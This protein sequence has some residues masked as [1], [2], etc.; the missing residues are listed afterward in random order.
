MLNNSIIGNISVWDGTSIL[1][2]NS[3]ISGSGG[4][5]DTIT[6]SGLYN[7]TGTYYTGGALP[8]GSWNSIPSLGPLTYNNNIT[9]SVEADVIIGTRSLKTFMEK[10]EDRLAILQPDPEK[11]EKFAA[12][13]A[14][15][16][17]Y[18]LLEALCSGDVPDMKPE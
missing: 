2:D 8:A 12:L 16:E 14:A 17:H 18:K 7:S 5:A 15:Y 4:S 11:L 6:L 1:T 13:K 3:I 9:M 10:V